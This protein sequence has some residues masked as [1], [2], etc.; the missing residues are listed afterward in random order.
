MRIFS[1]K[2][3]KHEPDRC[4]GLCMATRQLVNS[5]ARTRFGRTMMRSNLRAGCAAIVLLSTPAAAQRSARR[6]LHASEIAAAGWH[7][8]GDVVAALMPGDMASVDGFNAALTDGRM[9]FA[10]LSAAGSPQWMLRID[11]Q[12]MPLAVDG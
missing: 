4:R 10:G 12:R 1:S 2:S 9:P 7:R 8:L 5:T 11:G 3:P 6:V